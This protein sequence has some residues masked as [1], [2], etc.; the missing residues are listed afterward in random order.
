[1]MRTRNLTNRNKYGAILEVANHHKKNVLKVLFSVTALSLLS[2]SISTMTMTTN[3][4]R[5]SSRSVSAIINSTTSS[6]GG[7]IQMGICEV[8]AGGPCSNNIL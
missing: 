3:A 4:Q 8:A 1:M 5:Y 7:V 6:T 2:M